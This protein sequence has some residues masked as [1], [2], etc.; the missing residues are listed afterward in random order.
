MF[1][2]LVNE[3][4]IDLHI[5]VEGPVLIK[6]GLAQVSGPDMAWVRVFRNGREEVYL[7]GSSLKGALRSHAERIARTLKPEA[8]CDPFAD[9]SCGRIFDRKKPQTPEAYRDAC[10][11]CKLFGCTG[12]AGRLATTD[13]YAVGTPPEP[14]QRDGVGIDRFSGGAAHGAKFEL[15]V[16]TE[17]IF[18]TTLHLRNFELWQLALLGF[19]LQDL[20]D[21]LIRIGMGKSRGLGR[22]RGEVQQ[23][24]IDFL[25]PSA[26]HVVNGQL[27][28]RGVGSLFDGAREYGMVSPDEVIIPCTGALSG[29]GLR[30]TATFPGQT[31]PWSALGDRWVQRATQ[32]TDPLA[33][34][35]QGG[36]R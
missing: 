11:I 8:A 3:C 28:L 14:V 35:R 32:F 17:G 13:A 2:Q 18:A 20:A 36:R 30:T 26:P 34:E 29:N 6:S 25:G 31:F 22:V 1:K 23:V 19:V 7:P 24:R 33:Y 5:K 21:G 4:V 16:I 12:F 9:T 10:L 15:E 27:P